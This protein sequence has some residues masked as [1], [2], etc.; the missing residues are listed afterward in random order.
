MNTFSA[1]AIIPEQGIRA[2][3]ASPV[4]IATDGHDQSNSAMIVGRLLAANDGALRVLSVLKRMPAVNPEIQL[5][6]SPDVDASRRAERRRAVRQQAA[7]VWG[8]DAIDVELCEGDPAT[9]IARLAHETNATMIVSGLGRHRVMDRLFGD[10]TALRLIRVSAVPVFA[11]ASGL[12]HAPS[13]IVVAVDF[14]ETSL[15]AARLALEVA[16][17]NATVYLAHV[18]PRDSMLHEWNG[19]G[20]SYKDDAGDALQK[21]R[22]QLHIPPGLTVQRVLLQGDPAT[23]LLAFASS[24]NADLIAS[25]SHGHGFVARMLVGSVTTRIL[26]CSTCSVLCVPHAAAMTRARIT[27]EPSVVTIVEKPEW[28]ERLNAFSQ[29]NIGRR[30]TLEVDDPDIGAQAQEHDY[31]LLGATYDSHDGRVE[32]MFGELGDAGRHLTRSISDVDEIDTLTNER[33]QDI[34]LRIAHGAG[35]TLLTFAG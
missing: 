1:P 4:I 35:Q 17:P 23:E 21:M 18:G 28:S 22:E 9:L 2:N 24:V 5:P 32:L 30:G 10:E 31:P 3:R 13:R 7:R 11:V 33:G 14:S 15:R 8:E 16:S 19:W 25:G 27:V 26:R 6:L 12:S 34:A 29:R 20:L